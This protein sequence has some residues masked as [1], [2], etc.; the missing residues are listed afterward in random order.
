MK[1]TPR[2]ETNAA[3]QTTTKARRSFSVLGTVL[4]ASVMVTACSG[5][6][7]GDAPAPI[8]TSGDALATALQQEYGTEF[9]VLRNEDGAVNSITAMGA[10][11]IVGKDADAAKSAVATLIARHA[12]DLG[13]ASPKQLADATVLD[14]VGGDRQ[15][16]I[17][18]RT[19]SGMPV[20]QGSFTMSFDADGRILG[21][22]STGT[23]PTV[24][25]AALDAEAGKAKI[26]DAARV[27][28][29]GS[30]DTQPTL[31]MFEALAYPNEQGVLEPAYLGHVDGAGPNEAAMGVIVSGKDG[32]TLTTFPLEM[33]ITVSSKSVAHYLPS[34]HGVP[35]TT[36]PV[37]ATILPFPQGFRLEQPAGPRVSSVS[38]TYDSGPESSE[39][40]LSG[41]VKKFVDSLDFTAFDS[42]NMNPD[43][44]NGSVALG[45]AVDAQHNAS[46]VDQFYWRYAQQSPMSVPI[47][48]VVHHNRH[49]GLNFANNAAFNPLVNVVYYGDG[50][51]DA[52]AK[53]GRILPTATALD[54][55][56]HELTHAFVIKHLGIAYAGIMLG[57]SGALS[58]AI[59]DAVGIL[60]KHEYLPF[61]RAN[62]VGDTADVDHAGYRSL[63]HPQ[64]RVDSTGQRMVDNLTAQ[65]K[66]PLGSKIPCS[67]I[68]SGVNDNGCVHVNA[69]IG[70]NAFWLMTFGGK[71]DTSQQVVEQ[72]VGWDISRSIWLHTAS[73]VMP[74]Q[75]Y[76]LVAKD[77]IA[78][79]RKTFP[80][81]V[82]AVA[83]AWNAVGALSTSE[84]S[85]LAGTTC[86]VTKPISCV[87]RKDGFYCDEATLYSA[88]RCV[89]GAIAAGAQCSDPKLLCT[90]TSPDFNAPAAMGADGRPVCVAQKD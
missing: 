89:G 25:S 47:V 44:R 75:G 72:G 4:A 71:N 69:G 82:K 39:K 87:G 49:C 15:V 36:L 65:A 74:G 57:E 88:T 51:W 32:R 79:T 20:W 53:Q 35:G 8:A 54:V 60:V 12:T 83:C 56:A 59:A 77:Q 85:A 13:V 68:P 29:G 81:S 66:F 42:Q 28:A 18:P 48:N 3:T 64:T 38:T 90:R 84:V 37:E 41:V 5:G 23:V 16:A 33:G 61:L 6:P 31:D 50:D 34:P 14:L 73:A 67:S 24:A 17:R 86:R 45:S 11:R 62:I 78:F 27:A 1:T 10:S 80:Q 63:E 70:N 52:A 30:D 2:T 55:V 26:R 43:A 9:V 21:A 22:V 7:E 76:N 40:C 46:R 19:E 58:E